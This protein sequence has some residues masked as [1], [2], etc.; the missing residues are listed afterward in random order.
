MSIAYL[1]CFHCFPPQ[2]NP[3]HDSNDEFRIQPGIR[4]GSPT[5][6]RFLLLSPHVEPLLQ[7]VFSHQAF[8]L[9]THTDPAGFTL[10]QNHAAGFE[11]LDFGL[12]LSVWP[13]YFTL[14][15]RISHGGP[16]EDRIPVE[17]APTSNMYKFWRTTRRTWDTRA[18]VGI[19][20]P[21]TRNLNLQ[22]RRRFNGVCQ[23]NKF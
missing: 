21:F 14:T 13:G 9:D 22:V 18:L 2:S 5:E 3:N 7:I 16:S 12:N 17:T 15:S 6:P 19:T 8:P 1:S 20:F 23:E 11:C 10:F 4:E